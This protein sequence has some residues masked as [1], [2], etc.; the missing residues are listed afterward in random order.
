[1]ATKRTGQEY[2]VAALRKSIAVLGVI[3]ESS[4]PLG[5]SE[6]ARRA[7]VS[8]NMCL[9]ILDTLTDLGWVYQHAAS[10]VYELTL[11]PFQFFAGSRN[12]TTLLDQALPA[13]KD[14]NRKTGESTYL[15]V[16]HENKALMIHVIK[17]T[18]PIS[19]TGEI[20]ASYDL[21]ATAP[22]KVFLAWGD[23]GR[24]ALKH[25]L[26]AYTDKT[27]TGSKALRAE[28]DMIRERGYALNKEEYGPGL[29]G[30]AAPLFN[31]DREVIGAIGIFAPA[32]NVAPD[33]FEQTFATIVCEA[34]RAAS[35]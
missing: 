28:M 10:P 8:K 13:L 6:I 21:H 32:T 23:A 14:L 9:R 20:G 2:N 25:Q 24:Q 35:S 5:V 4:E 27:I 15:S 16:P 26:K 17:G 3:K 30:M 22:G 11:A 34:A 1:M 33:R 7:D 31:E 18:K 19:V 29:L 12:R